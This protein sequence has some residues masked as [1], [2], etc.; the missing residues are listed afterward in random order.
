MDGGD[1]FMEEGVMLGHALHHH[2]LGVLSVW[3]EEVHGGHCH[4][5]PVLLLVNCLPRHNMSHLRTDNPGNLNKFYVQK[6]C[7]PKNISSP[8]LPGH[9]G[10][11]GK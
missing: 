7:Y 9:L 3:D 6:K 4:E 11:S 10:W 2:V 1:V 8:E 5:A